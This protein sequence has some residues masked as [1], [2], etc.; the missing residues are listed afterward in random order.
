[1]RSTT[2]IWLVAR[3]Q[4]GI[5]ADVPDVISQGNQWW[6]S[7]NMFAVFS[8]FTA[9]NLGRP[10]LQWC[11]S[12]WHPP[13]HTKQSSHVDKT[14]SPGW[15]RQ[16]SNLMNNNYI[17]FTWILLRFLEAAHN[18]IFLLKKQCYSFKVD[19]GHHDVTMS[20]RRWWMK[21]YYKFLIILSTCVFSPDVKHENWSN[22]Q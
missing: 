19:F 9:S 3:H 11:K 17:N 4:Y 22:E 20:R 12:Y 21:L 1:M 16:V 6:W 10:R 15:Q 18:S 8:G 7:C 13:S 14:P 2:Q 5:S